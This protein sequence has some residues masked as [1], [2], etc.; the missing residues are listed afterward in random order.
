MDQCTQVMQCCDLTDLLG[1]SWGHAGSAPPASPL[2]SSWKSRRSLYRFPVSQGYVG[3]T[4]AGSGGRWLSALQAPPPTSFVRARP[5]HH[6]RITKMS[7][8]QNSRDPF[9]G[10]SRDLPPSSQTPQGHAHTFESRVQPQSGPQLPSAP[11]W[12]LRNLPLLPEGEPRKDPYFSPGL[13][14]EGVVLSSAHGGHW[15]L[16]CPFLASRDSGRNSVDS[17]RRE[18]N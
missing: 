11:T 5:H 2:A 10:R 12:V 7:K 15:G 9:E 6:C 13:E 14:C 16:A 17:G 18:F 8:P 4:G 3:D 1:G